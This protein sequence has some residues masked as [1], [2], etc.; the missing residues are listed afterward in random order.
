MSLKIHDG[1]KPAPMP[2]KRKMHI[3]IIIAACLVV[4]IAVV[5]FARYMSPR[6]RMI[7]AI[8][9]SDYDTALK[10]KNNHSDV[11]DENLLHSLSEQLTMIEMDFRDGKMDYE[12]ALS[13]IGVIKSLGDDSLKEAADQLQKTIS[14]IDYSQKA[15]NQGIAALEADEYGKAVIFFGDV[16]DSDVNNYSSAQQKRDEAIEKYRDEVLSKAN[17]KAESNDYAAAISIL[18]TSF[19]IIPDDHIITAKISEYH[20]MDK[21]QNIDAILSGASDAAAKGDLI[22][23]INLI[24]TNITKYDNDKRLSDKLQEYTSSFVSRIMSQVKAQEDKQNHEEAIRL[25]TDAIEKLP[26]NTELSDKLAQVQNAKKAMELSNLK[27][28]VLKEAEEAFSTDG[29]AKA[30]QILQSA[31]ELQNDADIINKISAYREYAPVSVYDLIELNKRELSNDA[32]SLID[33]FNNDHTGDGIIFTMYTT[34]HP[35]YREGSEYTFYTEKKYAKLT[36]RCAVHEDF[37]GEAVIEVYGGK[38]G[39]YGDGNSPL[40]KVNIDRSTKTFEINVDISGYEWITIDYH[41]SPNRTGR[42]KVICI[43]WAVSK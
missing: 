8:E 40:Y 21:N 27:E 5:L 13:Q 22:G 10:I 26:N 34:S 41:Y 42:G 9:H 6:Q 33:T 36:G 3:T 28:Q 29:Y 24:Q 14:D 1:G 38:E 32:Q 30:I 17:Q 23:A 12:T 15:Y 18:Q 16:I 35:I 39:Y 11:I 31:S 4:I 43:D 7:R 25:L 20:Q 2:Q 19:D 37:E